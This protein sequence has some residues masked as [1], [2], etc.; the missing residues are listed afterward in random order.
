MGADQGG[1]KAE[2]TARRGRSDPW[3]VTFA[4]LLV[5]SLVCAVV[6]L[7]LGS[8]LLVVR[9]VAVTGTD[10]I[11]SEEV[12][13]AVSVDTG[14]PLIRVD[15]DAGRADVERLDLVES[16]EVT[17][18]WP[19]TLKVEIVERQPLLAI[20]VGEEYR[21][22]DGDGVRI[23]DSST[24][25][26]THPLVTVTGEIEGNEAV[27]AAAEIV[28]EAPDSFLAQIQLIDARDTD[29]IRIELG[30]GSEVAWGDAGHTVHKS[31]ILRVLMREHPTEEGRVYDVGTPEQA[32]VR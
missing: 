4:V 24:R 25:P 9:D 13:A 7:L 3:K 8:R 27:R 26:G 31:E 23:E 30:D 15:L 1:E 21:L 14:T 17:R 2:A 6:W 28:G 5:V 12:E 32:I 10:R 11:T 29:E 16:A 18:G 22:V 19:A 20:A